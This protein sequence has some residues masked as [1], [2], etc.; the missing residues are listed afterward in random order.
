MQQ[1]RV[2]VRFRET[3]GGP[4][5][6]IAYFPRPSAKPDSVL[7]RWARWCFAADNAAL[8]RRHFTAP[9]CTILGVYVSR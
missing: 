7:I 1:I 3:L 5:E 6:E 8:N 2:Y 9:P 4:I